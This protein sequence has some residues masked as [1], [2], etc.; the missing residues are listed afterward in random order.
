MS[1]IRRREFVSSVGVLIGAA[2]WPLA[3]QAQQGKLFRVGYLDAGAPND[4]TVKNLR[5]Q[6]LLGMRDLGYIED[7]DFKLDDRY[8]EGQLDRLSVLAAE[9]AKIP[10]DIMAT[11][12]D[13]PIRAAQEASKTIPIVMPIA[14]DPVG[15]G[16][17]AS[18]AQP[19]GNIT[20]LSALAS[21]MAGKRVE[22][23]KEIVPAATRIAVLWN[24]SSQSKQTE[25]RDTLGPAKAMGVT[26]QSVEAQ[27]REE[28]DR[29]FARILSQHPDA[30]IVFTESLTLAFR[31]NIGQFA[32]A[33]RLPMVS[34]LREFT[35]VGGLA[36][37]GVNRAD[38][39]RRAATFV[40]KIIRGARPGNLPVEQPTKFELV[41]SLK[42]A[43]VL[44]LDVP[45][46]LLSR[47]D[48]VIE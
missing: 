18:L 43:R 42:S 8:A 15:S 45:P 23:L 17:I 39:W 32:L 11:G 9:L 21:D 34:E 25:W 6:F 10:V 47:A 20:G 14:A 38:L 46:I 44:G 3:A 48:E 30:V 29:G 35:D 4:A 27:S 2:A 13:A 22:L 16:F 19:G 1:A 28:L 40:H 41:I 33:N 24:S 31:K 5:R 12:G 36:S 7:R 26:L 37:Y